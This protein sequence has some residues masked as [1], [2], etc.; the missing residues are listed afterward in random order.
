MNATSDGELS[1][2]GRIV[3][4]HGS[5]VDVRFEDHLPTVNTILRA[6]NKQ[7]NCDRGAGAT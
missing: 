2:E 4:V 5:V 1:N 7:R 3:A 6:G